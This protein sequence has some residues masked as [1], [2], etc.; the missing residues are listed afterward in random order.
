MN[1]SDGTQTAMPSAHPRLIT[2]GSTPGTSYPRAI[3]RSVTWV[4]GTS[5]IM[6]RRRLSGTEP[7]KSSEAG[8]GNCCF[9]RRWALDPG[10]GTPGRFT[11]LQAYHFGTVSASSRNICWLNDSRFNPWMVSVILDRFVSPE[12]CFGHSTLRAIFRPERARRGGMGPLS[13]IGVV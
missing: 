7:V 11:P 9:G 4:T 3:A 2:L 8:P 13:G 6:A 10:S 1:N 12:A 5:V